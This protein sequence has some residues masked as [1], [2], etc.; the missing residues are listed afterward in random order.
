MHCT[1]PKKAWKGG[2]TDTFQQGIT[3][4]QP[5]DRLYE[6]PMLLPCGTCDSCKFGRAREWSLRI[7]HETSMHEENDF[8]TLTYNEDN[9]PDNYSADKTEI[10]RFIKRLRNEIIHPLNKVEKKKGLPLTK[11]KYYGVMEYGKQPQTGLLPRPHYHIIINGFSFPDRVYFKTTE[12][13]KD[14]YTSRI[15]ASLWHDKNTKGDEKGFSSIGDVEIESANYV[16][17]YTMKKR[18]EDDLFNYIKNNNLEPERNFMSKG[19]GYTWFQ[20]YKHD[21]LKGYITHNNRKYPIPRYY[22]ELLQQ[23]FPGHMIGLKHV[24]QEY[25]AQNYEEMIEPQRQRSNDAIAK[26]KNKLLKRTL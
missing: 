26:A 6:K 17:R 13:G 16:A 4:K 22:K 12:A 14:I 19:I 18:D 3:F 1:S 15:L 9:V 11:I 21:L 5:E 7:S 20:K 8:I 24:F 25:A 2:V 10:P 23:E